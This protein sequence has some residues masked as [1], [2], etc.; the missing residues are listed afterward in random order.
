MKLLNLSLK[1]IRIRPNS[2]VGPWLFS[3][4]SISCRCHAQSD[5]KVKMSAGG[6]GGNNGNSNGNT[7]GN[8]ERDDD[9]TPRAP[10]HQMPILLQIWIW[11]TV[12]VYLYARVKWRQELKEKERLFKMEEEA[13]LKEAQ[14]WEQF[15]NENQQISSKR[16]GLR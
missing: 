5:S 16:E 12:L 11:L 3:R 9:F 14:A 4:P 6:G 8:D 7:R 1:S 2:I 10:S 15:L 13:Q